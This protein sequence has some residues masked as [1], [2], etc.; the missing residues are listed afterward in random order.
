[1]L[2]ERH[3][4]LMFMLRVP[5]TTQQLDA[6]WKGWRRLFN[7]LHKR[8]FAKVGYGSAYLTKAGWHYLWD[9]M[10]EK[11]DQDNILEGGDL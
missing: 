3:I 8:G 6:E 4:R 9:L 2:T 5:R 10:G 1:M 7:R 11:V